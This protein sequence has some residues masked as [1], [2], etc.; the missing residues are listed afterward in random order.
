[1]LTRRLPGLVGGALA[2]SSV[3]YLPAA[4][5][6]L[7]RSYSSKQPFPIKGRVVHQT[8]EEAD[9]ERKKIGLP[10]W[11][12]WVLYTKTETYKRRMFRLYLTIFGSTAILL[13][14]YMRDRFYEH[15]QLIDVKKKYLEDPKSLS[16]YEYLM[17]KNSGQEKL[18]PLELKKFKYYCLMR[19]EYRRKNITDK[20]YVFNPTPEELNEWYS[21]QARIRSDISPPDLTG[22]NIDAEQQESTTKIHRH[23][24]P[25]QDTTSFYEDKAQSYDDEVKWE[26][27]GIFMGSKRNW[28]MKRLKGD[29]LE[30]SCGTGR[31]IPYLRPDQINSITY[32]DSARS[33]VAV[34]REKFHK[35]FP[36]FQKV[37]FTVGKAEDLIDLTGGNEQLKYDTIV[38]SFGLCAHE[39]PVKALKNMAK[40]L[41]PGG[42]IVLL[43]HGRSDYKFINNYMDD[44]SEKRMKTWA[45]R[46]NL[47][48]GELVDE[49]NLDITIEKRPHLGTTWMLVLKRPE[50]RIQIEE[51][52]FWNK[53]W[54]IDPHEMKK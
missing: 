33:M 30:V 46:W 47:D 25:A 10:K 11:F 7:I 52:S 48:I 50:D 3:S 36:D 22:D 17:L 16:E 54:G 45:C 38:Q 24:V 49:A 8:P 34:T 12:H 19:K 41:K 35:A 6:I 43:E 26:E 13:Y 14:F 28:I 9:I 42:R 18:R 44:R 53:L 15:V 23:I 1:M 2:R 21:K 32:L 29:V 40:L 4:S 27:R 39:D 51:K 20:E 37:V 5:S 31:N